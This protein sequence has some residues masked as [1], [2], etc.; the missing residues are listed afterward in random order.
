M[1]VLLFSSNKKYKSCSNSLAFPVF[2]PW[3]VFVWANWAYTISYC[4][5]YVCTYM[6]VNKITLKVSFIL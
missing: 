4:F 2:S 6:S 1:P 5:P 3:S